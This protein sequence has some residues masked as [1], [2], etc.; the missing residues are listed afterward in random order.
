[1]IFLI[2]AP[3][4]CGNSSVGRALASQAG[5]RGFE[6]HLPLTADCAHLISCPTL[7]IDSDAEQFFGGQPKQLYDALKC[8]IL[9]IYFAIKSKKKKE[10][11]I[12]VRQ[13]VRQIT[14]ENNNKNHP[15]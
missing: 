8:P 9:K 5:G 15:G 6:S 13:I 10:N 12:F 7:V 1:M 11:A 14:H 2:F 3:P 4:N